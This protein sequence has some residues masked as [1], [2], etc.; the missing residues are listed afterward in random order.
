[1]QQGDSGTSGENGLHSERGLALPIALFLTALLG[2][3]GIA[4]LQMGIVESRISARQRDRDSLL[5]I[6]ESGA[7]LVKAWFD[8]PVSGDPSS[9]PRHLFLGHDLRDPRLFDR[10][11]RLIDADGD[12]NTPPIPADGSP[13][14]ELYRQGREIT[15]GAPHLDLFQ[16]PYRGPITT[17]LAGT[18]GGPDIVLEDR[19]G[20]I[21]LIDLLNR[22]LFPEQH[23][24]GRIERI[25]ISAPIAV[26]RASGFARLG[27]ASI[28][29]TAARYAV[30][31]E[32][33]GVPE[34]PA[35]SRPIAR[36][37][38]RI[39]LAEIPVASPRGPLE[40][41]GDLTVT[42]PL[43]AHWGRIIAAGDITL[44][45]TIEE[46]DDQVDSAFPY[47]SYARRI[48]GLST[49]EDLAAWTSAPD[50]SI[51]D[52]WLKVVAGGIL[53][54]WE[55]LADQPFPF[56]P[57]REI[58][59]DHSNL[60]QRVPGVSCASFDYELWKRLAQGRSTIG[61]DLRYF[62][63]DAK[64]G[65]FRL[66]GEGTPRSVRD[67]TH[68][69]DGIFFFD[70]Q[71]SGPPHAGNLT[72]PVVIS[73]GDW[74]SAGVIFLNA[75]SFQATSLRGTPR[76]LL[77]PGEPFDDRDHDSQWDAV[78]ATVNIRYPTSIGTGTSADD[79]LKDAAAIQSGAAISPDGEEY[80]VTTST[81]RD[82]RG[83]P[84]LAEVNHFGILYNSG[85]IVAEGD[86]VVYG[87]LI[88]GGDIT[89]SNFGAGTLHVY[90][91]ER[92]NTGEWPPPEIEMPRTH[93]T[94]WQ[95]SRP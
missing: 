51:E 45:S 6:A 12:P 73:G 74:W 78:E 20:V 38:V 80:A 75:R 37:T 55:A 77:P 49:G 15:P 54:G 81:Q 93:V 13:G 16:K 87:S 94:Y 29:V 71:D 14:R 88:A 63:Y 83:I 68:D 69:R 28:E 50:D 42:G 19:P 30:L 40:S 59:R 92:L 23:A 72:P 33:A 39:G 84:L 90:F 58:D 89:Q 47:A 31:A 32:I 5:N 85:D 66:G 36:A 43:R 17:S 27:V 61:H 22:D 52:P 76:V 1:M 11:R 41:C 26:P 35:G 62:A 57:L 56:D 10:S 2:A 34:S 64:T 44:A 60:F 8:R 65:L 86:V 95:T 7:R 24:T 48:E 82:A 4:C 67:W 70:T 46:L 91:D 25:A 53:S 9:G 21:D 18:R 3:L 79:F